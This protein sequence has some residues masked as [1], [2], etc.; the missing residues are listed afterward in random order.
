MNCVKHRGERQ[1]R[2]GCEEI[3]KRQRLVEKTGS[4]NHAI[5]AI[6]ARCFCGIEGASG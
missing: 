4:G 5:D 1:R 6:Q 3:G 2:L